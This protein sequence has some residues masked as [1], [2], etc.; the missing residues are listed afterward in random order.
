MKKISIGDM[1]ITK[2]VL[3]DNREKLIVL[4]DHALKEALFDWAVPLS[5]TIVVL[6]HVIEEYEE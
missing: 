4:R 5:H 2:A 3:V 6:S 1:V